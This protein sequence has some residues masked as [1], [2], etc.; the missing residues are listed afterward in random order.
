MLD[1][2]TLFDTKYVVSIHALR[3]Q[4][5]M[6]HRHRHWLP[7]QGF[8]PRPPFPEGDAE[9]ENAMCRLYE[10]SIHALRFQRA[11]HHWL[12]KSGQGATFQ[13][14]PSVS[15]GRCSA[16]RIPAYSLYGF[17][18]RPPFP[19]GDAGSSHLGAQI[20]DVSIH[21]LRFQRAMPGTG[22]AGE[23]ITW[24]QSTPSVSRGRCAIAPRMMPTAS[25]FQSTPSVSRGRCC[26]PQGEP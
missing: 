25:M 1:V 9:G 19:E 7:W 4:R 13:S 14:T 11:M 6:R 17:N 10:V 5:A 18:P 20:Q 3:F 22:A 26:F 16:C 23:P 2:M 8:N 12:A 21:A 15:R 24:F